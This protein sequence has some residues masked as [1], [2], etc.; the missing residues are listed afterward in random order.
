MRN[1]ISVRIF[2]SLRVISGQ[3]TVGNIVH[4]LC[5]ILVT[6]GTIWLLMAVLLFRDYSNHLISILTAVF[7]EIH[8]SYTFFFFNCLFLPIA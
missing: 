1:F 2:I 6:V 7:R 8:R 5:G 4:S 3:D